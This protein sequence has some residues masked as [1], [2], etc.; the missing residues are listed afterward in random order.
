MIFDVSL[1]DD[2]SRARIQEKGIPFYLKLQKTVGK[3]SVLFDD[4]FKE[5]YCRYYRLNRCF[6]PEDKEKYFTVF[7]EER[8]TK[9]CD[10]RQILMKLYSIKGKSHKGERSE[11]KAWA[12]FTSKMIASIDPSQPV[13]DSVVLAKLHEDPDIRFPN[14][15]IIAPENIADKKAYKIEKHVE[16]YNRL[17]ETIC[18][19]KEEA[20]QQGFFDAFRKEFEDAQNLTEEKILDFYLWGVRAK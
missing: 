12:S 4:E 17:K 1:I 14:H 5:Q 3:E 6:S 15:S 20:K 10:F 19:L 16:R 11:G 18:R 2:E 13:W 9:N 7:E 8:R